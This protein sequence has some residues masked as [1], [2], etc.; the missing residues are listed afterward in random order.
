MCL[1]SSSPPKLSSASV[2]FDFNDSL[3]DVA[4]LPSIFVSVDVM[5]KKKSDLPK[6]AFCVSSFVF[7]S[8]LK[9]SERSV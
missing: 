4:P 5:R 2:L 1:L 6:D 7:T 3:N 9:L 8:Q